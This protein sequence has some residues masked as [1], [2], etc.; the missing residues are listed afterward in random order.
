MGGASLLLPDPARGRPRARLGHESPAPGLTH[1]PGPAS[2]ST[3]CSVWSGPMRAN[4]GQVSAT[5]ATTAS[6]PT[7]P[8]TTATTGPKRAATAPLSTAP[9]SFEKPTN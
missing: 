3:E 7:P 1:E 2:G 9:S 8:L 4:A 5:T 6:V